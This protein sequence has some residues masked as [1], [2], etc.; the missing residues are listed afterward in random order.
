VTEILGGD[1]N[2]DQRTVT[3]DSLSLGQPLDAVL[4]PQ[5]I[6]DERVAEGRGANT[7]ITISRPVLQRLLDG[8]TLGLAIRPLGPID[9]T[10]YA[11]EHVGGTLAATLH[12]GL[13]TR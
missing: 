4:N 1:P 6:I 8:R 7:R 12:F 2:W 10:F 5:M 3:L 11:S 13:Q 9:A